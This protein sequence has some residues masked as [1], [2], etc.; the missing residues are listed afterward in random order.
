MRKDKQPQKK[1]L[2]YIDSTRFM[3]WQKID[4]AQSYRLKDLKEGKRLI[5]YKKH[6]TSAEEAN[7][8]LA[9]PN[10]TLFQVTSSFEKNS[11]GSLRTLLIPTPIM[12]LIG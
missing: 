1:F 8:H 5:S 4:S 7:Q 11:V 9:S 3:S 6:F 2:H 12:P 10:D